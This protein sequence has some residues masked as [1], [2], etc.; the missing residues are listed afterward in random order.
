MHVT[1]RCPRLSLKSRNVSNCVRAYLQG[2]DAL[3]DQ[4]P[5]FEIEEDHDDGLR[6]VPPSH[7]QAHTVPSCDVDARR[8]PDMI[9]MESVIS[10]EFRGVFPG[11][12]SFNRMQSKC[13]TTVCEVQ[14]T[15]TKQILDSNMS[16]VVRFE[17]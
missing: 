7:L 16:A 4:S 5:S 2:R 1:A 13:I 3:P 9:A 11:L 15:I 14:H 8:D 17:A 6:S 10:P 12:R